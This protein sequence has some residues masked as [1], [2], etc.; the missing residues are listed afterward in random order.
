MFGIDRL[1]EKIETTE[2]TVECP[3]KGCKTKVERQRHKF[4]RKRQFQCPV[5]KIYI[6]PSTFEYEQEIDN[7][8]WHDQEDIALLDAIKT[9][10]R[11]SRMARDNSED[12]LTFNIF[13]Y[14]EKADQIGPL[15]SSLT[16]SQVKDPEIIYWS[17][18]RKDDGIWTELSKSREE[19][20]E[21][22][23]GGSEPDLI[24]VSAD[25]LFFV[26]AKLT[27]TNKTPGHNKNKDNYLS[28]GN[29]WYQRVFQSDFETV[30]IKEKKY[31]LMRLWL[32]G[33]WL[34]YQLG[35]AFYLVNLVLSER[36]K[37]IEHLMEAHFVTDIRKN[38]VRM[39]WED[40]YRY[41]SKNYEMSKGRDLL[42]NYFENKTIGYSRF[43]DLQ[44]AFVSE[45]AFHRA[46]ERI[47]M[48]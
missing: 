26:E 32:L 8:L 42:L 17:Y 37:N 38:I 7:L 29:S 19:F 33:T 35:R 15:L 41:V 23:L 11:E 27:A 6:S 24:I 40:I 43:G 30:A 10:K 34:A 20:G 5:H 18:S 46:I 31:E 2:T 25:E 4:Q 3:V 44:R 16:K 36:E 14:L 21:R 28:G 13:R 47:S 22:K 9:V 1:K 39:S 45:V 12:A 48:S